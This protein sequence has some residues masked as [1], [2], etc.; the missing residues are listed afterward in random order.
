MASYKIVNDKP[1]DG[2][3]WFNQPLMNDDGTFQ[4]DEEGNVLV[5]QMVVRSVDATKVDKVSKFL[6]GSAYTNFNQIS[7]ITNEVAHLRNDLKGY[8]EQVYTK[9]AA[10]NKFM[11]LSDNESVYGSK[12][13]LNGIKT[14]MALNPSDNEVANKGYVDKLAKSFNETIAKLGD[15]NSGF[16]HKNGEETVTGTKTFEKL[17]LSDAVPTEDNELVNKAYVDSIASSSGGSG[18]IAGQIIESPTPIKDINLYPTKGATLVSGGIYD[19]F[20][21]KI[22]ELYTDG[23]LKCYSYGDKAVVDTT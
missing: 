4:K 19:S 7:E 5:E 2:D 21:N 14:A 17:P 9:E 20:I 8:T 15:L 13:F 10:N 11:T 6:E 22:G 18:L 16:F 1:I 23:L 3:F 12:H